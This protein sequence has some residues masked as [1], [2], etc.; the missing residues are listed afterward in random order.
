MIDNLLYQG[1]FVY[2]IVTKER[3]KKETNISRI[4]KYYFYLTMFMITFIWLD[5]V[6]VS[7]LKSS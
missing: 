1:L 6:L 4:E 5:L 2:F 3:N 7:V